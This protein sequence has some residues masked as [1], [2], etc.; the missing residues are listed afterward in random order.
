MATKSLSVQPHSILV[1]LWTTVKKNPKQ[2]VN[3]SLACP[4]FHSFVFCRPQGDGSF[5][6][7][8]VL[9]RIAADAI[10]KHHFF[11]PFWSVSQQEGKYPL[12]L[13]ETLWKP[14]HTFVSC[15]FWL[16]VYFSEVKIILQMAARRV[17]AVIF[18]GIDCWK[19]KCYERKNCWYSNINFR[20]HYIMVSLYLQWH[21]P[22]S[23]CY[24]QNP[25]IGAFG[26]YLA[27]FLHHF[28]YFRVFSYT[29][30]PYIKFLVKL[31]RQRLCKFMNIDHEVFTGVYSLG[32]GF[33]PL[34]L[35]LQKSPNMPLWVIQLVSEEPEIQSPLL[36]EVWL[37]LKCHS[38]TS[39]DLDFCGP[40]IVH[41]NWTAP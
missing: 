25:S 27:F 33:T 39:T 36:C 30:N 5:Q 6:L 28:T 8:A 40:L 9:S 26:F 2:N 23:L 41:L 29:E 34:R 17:K 38:P 3:L 37:K 20:V 32:Q 18:L 13:R 15:Q 16:T 11:W 21:L 7:C 12:Y 35:W 4:Y 1:S 10:I 31:F 14:E 19:E 22:L 24:L